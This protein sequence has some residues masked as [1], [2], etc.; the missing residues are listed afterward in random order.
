MVARV[1]VLALVTVFGTWAYQEKPPLTAAEIMKQVAA[2]QDREQKARTQFV[3]DETVHRVMRRKDG[4]L[5]RS[6]MVRHKTARARN[7]MY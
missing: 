2:N 6:F 1:T 5:L 3:Y 4:K 7:A